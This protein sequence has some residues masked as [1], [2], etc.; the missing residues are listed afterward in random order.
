MSNGKDHGDFDMS[1]SFF[2][3]LKAYCMKSQKLFWIFIAAV[4]LIALYFSSRSLLSKVAEKPI[5]IAANSII[6]KDAES[7]SRGRILFHNKCKFCHNAYSTETI[8]G[9]GLEG[10]LKHPELPVSRRPATPDN[11]R[12]QLRKPF[13]RMPSFAY[14][15]EE[16]VEDLIAFLNTL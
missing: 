5:G 14:L 1:A 15:S 10:V 12:G 16:E 3:Y 9:P 2:L 13:S 6:K 4:I 8:V 7:I 11:I